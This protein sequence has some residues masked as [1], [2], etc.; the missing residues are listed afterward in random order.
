[1]KLVSIGHITS[2]GSSQCGQV[3]L[4]GTFFAELNGPDTLNVFLQ[5]VQV[6]IF[7]I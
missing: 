1:M 6:M 4:C 3:T 7:S 2:L 5:C